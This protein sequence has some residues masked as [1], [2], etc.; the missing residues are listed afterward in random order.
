AVE[1][2]HALQPRLVDQADACVPQVLAN[3]QAEWAVA[4]DAACRELRQLLNP[5]ALEVCGQ[6]HEGS[7]DGRCKAL[8]GQA[9]L[10]DEHQ[11]LQPCAGQPR[12][13]LVWDGGQSK[14]VKVHNP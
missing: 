2:E 5:S 10:V 13:Q 8:D 3:Q 4:F 9:E 11:A 7:S 12:G 1:L 14:C 6:Q